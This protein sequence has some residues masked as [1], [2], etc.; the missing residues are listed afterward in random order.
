M[1]IYHGSKRIIKEPIPKG[2]DPHNDYGPAFYLTLDLD[3]AKSWA[4]KNDSVGI[5]NKYSV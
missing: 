1:N 3:S 2:S 5:V 4:C